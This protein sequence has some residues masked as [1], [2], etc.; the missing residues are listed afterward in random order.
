[1]EL[2][3]ELNLPLVYPNERPP[4]RFGIDSNDDSDGLPI[5]LVNALLSPLLLIRYLYVDGKEEGNLVG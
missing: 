1:V 2:N 4:L 3:K 5:S